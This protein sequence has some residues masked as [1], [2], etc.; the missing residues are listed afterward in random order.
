MDV[1]GLI[2]GKHK[3]TQNF[4]ISH[5][6]VWHETIAIRGGIVENRS[7]KA[8]YKVDCSMK[9]IGPILMREGCIVQ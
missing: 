2:H 8:I 4:F 5:N 6:L 7:R 3:H 9:D 1:Y